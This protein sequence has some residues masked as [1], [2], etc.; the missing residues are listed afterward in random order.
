MASKGLNFEIENI[1]ELKGFLGV[2][3]ECSQIF[4]GM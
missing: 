3:E 1:C 2:G 4:R